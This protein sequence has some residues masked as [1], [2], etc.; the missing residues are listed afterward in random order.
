MRERERKKN[1]LLLL[2]LPTAHHSWYSVPRP[3]SSS[4]GGGSDS[5]SGGFTQRNT[6]T[7]STSRWPG[8]RPYGPHLTQLLTQLNSTTHTNKQRL[9]SFFKKLNINCLFVGLSLVSNSRPRI[10]LI[11][12]SL[13]LFQ[14]VCVCCYLCVSKW[15]CVYGDSING[16]ANNSFHTHFA[17]V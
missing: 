11:W 4:S 1:L 7:G 5:D 13:L 12:F 8:R 10:D 2:L 15:V 9:N 6:P 3:A 17:A 14:V 16:A